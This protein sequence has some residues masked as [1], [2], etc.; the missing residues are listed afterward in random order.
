MKRATSS[1]HDAACSSM[2]TLAFSMSMSEAVEVSGMCWDS[3]RKA[4]RDG[5]VDAYYAGARD[6]G[7]RRADGRRAP[8]P[9]RVVTSSLL[10]WIR[11]RR[12]K[13]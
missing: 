6:L 9:L 10:A 4:I 8:L 7:R 1:P 2:A 13:D 5:F 3:V 12:V 11:S